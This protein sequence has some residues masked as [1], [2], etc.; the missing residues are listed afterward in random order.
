MHGGKPQLA[1]KVGGAQA[2]RKG[3]S[4]IEPPEIMV[5]LDYKSK[6]SLGYTHNPAQIMPVTGQ[7]ASKLMHYKKN[8]SD[9]EDF[10]APS[11]NYPQSK[12][13]QKAK[14][15]SQGLETMSQLKKQQLMEAVNRSNF[16][17]EE[18]EEFKNIDIEVEQINAKNNS[19]EVEI[20]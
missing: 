9:M 8:S 5:D 16:I 3:G 18:N 17:Y 19:I 7:L 13:I 20:Q 15:P 2:R 10:L 4:T 11:S 6:S 12:I 1:K 14:T